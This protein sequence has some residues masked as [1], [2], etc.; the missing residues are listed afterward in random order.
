M[1]IQ[2][3]GLCMRFSHIMGLLIISVIS[4]N[5]C[6]DKKIDFSR[7]HHVV[8]HLSDGKDF[9]IEKWKIFQSAAL[10]KDYLRRQKR[11]GDEVKNMSLLYSNINSQEIDLYSKA[12][13][14][15]PGVPFKNYFQS[16]SLEDRRL[17]L[18]VAGKYAMVDQECQKKLNSSCLTAQLCG[19]YFDKNIVS[20]KIA[21]HMERLS[22]FLY[23]RNTVVQDNLPYFFPDICYDTLRYRLTDEGHIQLV[24]ECLKWGSYDGPYNTLLINNND[25]E[26]VTYLIKGVDSC[27]EYRVTAATP[28][29]TDEERNN[30][31]LLRLVNRDTNRD[32]PIL[33]EHEDDIEYSRFSPS[34]EYLCTQSNKM[35]LLSKIMRKEDNSLAVF[36]LSMPTSASCLYAFFNKKST[37]LVL[38][39]WDQDN[40]RGG[41]SLWDITNNDC[42]KKFEQDGAFTT[43]IYNDEGDRLLIISEEDGVSTQTLWNTANLSDIYQI[44]NLR[45]EEKDLFV[46]TVC[47]PHGK[48]WAS[49]TYAGKVIF[50]NEIDAQLF[51]LEE[52]LDKCVITAKNSTQ[53][54]IL[55]SPDAFFVAIV[56]PHQN[57]CLMVGLYSA[58]NYEKLGTWQTSAQG[59]GFTFDSCQLILNL[60]KNV[61][62]KIPLFNPNDCKNLEDLGLNSSI[63]QLAA[64]YRLAKVHQSKDTVELYEEEP[65]YKVLQSLSRT[66]RDIIQRSLPVPTVINNNKEL[67][68][69]GKD[70]LKRVEDQYDDTVK[71]IQ[72]WWKKL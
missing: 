4:Q 58:L 52:Q 49:V 38:N 43:G 30:Q 69:I 40:N 42:V 34:G 67:I 15:E 71:K 56:Y 66:S 19:V 53:I 70:V 45:A 3:E 32:T 36:S 13:E 65:D 35:V 61:W 11:C 50:T 24:P 47:A 16:L 28:K 31:R 9:S 54:K 1:V 6:M 5:Q 7:Q 14:C 44:G 57:N 17:L 48:E 72:D 18:T 59:I 60:G 39:C 20:S 8:L 10:H 63:H 25:K 2:Q 55:Y 46:K 21:P 62:G 68:E 27:Y 33:I 12:C 22:W 37:A 26:F 23:C 51:S 64:L 29:S 41:L